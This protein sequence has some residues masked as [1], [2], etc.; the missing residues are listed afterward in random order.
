MADHS[1]LPLL[2]QLRLCLEKE[3]H[4]NAS[5]YLADLHELCESSGA[6][7]RKEFERIVRSDK[8]LWLGMGTIGDLDLHDPS[9]KQKF[10]D[11][12]YA[13]AKICTHSKLRSDYSADAL[14]IF[15]QIRSK[16]QNP[17]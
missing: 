16:R 2:A 12:Y 9:I 6:D 1:L 13:F 17:A 3:G 14:K 10:E 7:D 15:E 4:T 8:Y 11:T 5:A